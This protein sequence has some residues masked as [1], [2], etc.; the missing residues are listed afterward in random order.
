MSE[1]IELVNGLNSKK[2]LKY[3]SSTTRLKELERIH[4]KNSKNAKVF[5]PPVINEEINDCD[6]DL[7]LAR[8]KGASLILAT[9]TDGKVLVA[10]RIRK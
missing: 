10:K 9:S 5:I 3:M 2:C 7:H 8:E 1:T 4:G 6:I